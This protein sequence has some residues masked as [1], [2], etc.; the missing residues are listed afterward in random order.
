MADS[1][2]PRI[3]VHSSRI[4]WY[5]VSLTIFH[6]VLFSFRHRYQ[7]VDKKYGTTYIR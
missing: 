5:D 4:R 2:I 7:L 3:T 6:L 1:E